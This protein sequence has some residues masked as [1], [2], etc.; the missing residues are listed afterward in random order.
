MFNRH[1][2]ALSSVGL[3]GFVSPAISARSTAPDRW[4]VKSSRY[5]PHQSTQETARRQGQ[6]D[7][8]R[9]RVE[10]GLQCLSAPVV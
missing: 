1:L 2:F 6:I 5:T 3:A 9:L 7:L 4:R 8:G 10:N